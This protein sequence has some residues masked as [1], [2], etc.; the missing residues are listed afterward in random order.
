MNKAIILLSVLALAV[1]G[2]RYHQITTEEDLYVMQANWNVPG[3][4]A[5]VKEFEGLRL[6]AYQDSVGVWTIGY[7]H[8]GPEVKKGL[9]IT[10]AQADA[11][12]QQDL[13]KFANCVNTYITARLN[14]NQ[15]GALISWSYNVGCGSLQTSTLRRRMNAGENPNTVASEELPKWVK[16]GGQT[17]PGLVRRRNAEVAFFKS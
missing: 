11:Y 15:V 1:S 8:T 9:T 6:T 13:S 17:L 3:T 16:A 5:L 12:L 10:Q 2:H 7:G 4:M 14:P